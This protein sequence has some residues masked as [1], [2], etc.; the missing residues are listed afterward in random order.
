MRWNTFEHAGGYGA[1]V[2]REILGAADEQESF[3]LN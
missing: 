2:L 1:H 3:F